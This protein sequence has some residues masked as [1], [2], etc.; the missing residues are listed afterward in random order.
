V[1]A[2]ALTACGG[3]GVGPLDSGVDSGVVWQK[4]PRSVHLLTLDAG[5]FPPT[6]AHPS[7]LVYVPDGF[8][9]EPPLDLVVY[10]HGFDNCVVNIIQDA[11][12]SCDPDGGTPA[13]AAY[14]L[15]AQLDASNKNALL[16]CPELSFDA[17]TGNPGRLADPGGFRALLT[18]TLADLAPVL[19]PQTPAD[20]GT[21]VVASHSG[22]YEAAAAILREADG[23]VPAREVWLFDSLYGNTQDFD[24]WVLSDLT[25]LVTVERRF[26][27]VYTATGGTLA[28]SQAMA[29]RAA[30]WVDAGVIADDRTT[31]TWM[32]PEY[33]HG[34]LFKAS[35]LAHD[36]V[37]KYYFR[38]M[39][40]TS[41]LRDR[42]P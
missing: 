29:D 2:V 33:H 27:T 31:A 19:G 42:P 37:P 30:T 39:L 40:Q 35:M 25:D 18:E 22:G 20:V 34:L 11:G 21:M 24:D 16:V 14:A 26:A 41:T 6:A 17:A 38:Q 3:V 12:A 36:D 4:L 10:L 13:R 5:A 9:L 7:A 8:S 32:P 23:G 28:T 1:L 15:A